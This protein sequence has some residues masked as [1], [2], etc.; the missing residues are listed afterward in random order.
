MINL[1]QDTHIHT[2]YSP[3]ADQ[4]ASF[5]DYIRK[6]KILNL[7]EIIF[8][9]HVDFDAAHPLFKDTIDYDKYIKDFQKENIELK[10]L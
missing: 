1:K 3:D 7:E 5:K 10:I 9:D 8:T 6:A 2:K 4:N